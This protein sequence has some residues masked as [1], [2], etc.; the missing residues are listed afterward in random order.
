M[1][2]SFV[3]STETNVLHSISDGEN[4]LLKTSEVNNLFDDAVMSLMK[5]ELG[6]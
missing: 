3:I 4:V 2:M 1:K 6:K 5:F